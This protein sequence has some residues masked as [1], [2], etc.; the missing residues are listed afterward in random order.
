MTTKHF[1]KKRI[2][3]HVFKDFL[4]KL[5]EIGKLADNTVYLLGLH[6][7]KFFSLEV[8]IIITTFFIK[9]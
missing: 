6:K 9:Y 4:V 7:S 3:Q 1:T 2:A 5:K 8:E